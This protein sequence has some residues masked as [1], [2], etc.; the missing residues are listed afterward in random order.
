MVCLQTQKAPD[1]QFI[2]VATLSEGII[3]KKVVA[4]AI[5]EQGINPEKSFP[6]VI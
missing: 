1:A 4:K 2:V 3:E 6:H 5:K